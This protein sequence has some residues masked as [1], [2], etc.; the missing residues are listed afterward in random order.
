MYLGDVEAVAGSSVTRAASPPSSSKSG[1][2]TVEKVPTLRGN[3]VRIHEHGQ[4]KRA[5]RRR[6][7][8]L[9]DII[10]IEG[11]DSRSLTKVQAPSQRV[12]PPQGQ[13]LTT[14][15]GQGVRQ[16]LNHVVEPAVVVPEV[17]DH[18]HGTDVGMDRHTAK[19]K[20]PN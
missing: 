5:K 9:L 1:A 12:R 2:E 10:I 6:F 15:K 14:K 7:S 20:A 17:P 3:I 8:C 13:V 18:H 19:S 11:G 16:R 4:P